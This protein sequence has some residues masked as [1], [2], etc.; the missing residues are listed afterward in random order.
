VLGPLLRT[1]AVQRLLKSRIQAGPAGPTPEERR[2][3]NSLLWGE[4]RDPSGAVVTSRMETPDG[5][6]LTRLTAVDL[7]E[8]TL[9]GEV[10]P[11]FQTPARAFGADYVLGFP[12][13]RREDSA[14]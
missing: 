9:A 13:V 6:E 10:K 3:H 2:Q 8:R 14:S 1:G 7:A 11:G 5:Y 12:G 4:A